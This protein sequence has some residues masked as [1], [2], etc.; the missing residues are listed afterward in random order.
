[1][2]TKLKKIFKQKRDKNLYIIL[3][4]IVVSIIAII[5]IICLYR[6]LL[7]RRKKFIRLAE[8]KNKTDD[9]VNNNFG[10][11]S[12]ENSKRWKNWINNFHKIKYETI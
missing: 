2:K 4:S 6:Y 10:V 3:I 5:F 7:K 11:L 8:E 9:N 12:V 1:M